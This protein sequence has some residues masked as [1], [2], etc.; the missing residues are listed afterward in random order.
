MAI[1]T[2]SAAPIPNT[3]YAIICDAY[4]D[5]GLIGEGEEPNSE[6][7]ASA[8]RRLNKLCNYLQTQGLKLWVQQDLPLRI[9]PGVGRYSLGPL[10]NVP[11][12]KPRRVI[13]AYYAQSQRP[14][15]LRTEDEIA[16]GVVLPNPL[17]ASSE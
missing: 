12:I 14:A 7:C 15:E 13:E 10:G 8:L 17:C 9:K 1:N 2:A 6:K 16:A 11:M 4:L 3:A 5:A